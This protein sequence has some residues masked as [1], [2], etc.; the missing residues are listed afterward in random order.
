MGDFAELN[1]RLKL[2]VD[3]PNNTIEIL[4]YMASHC[5]QKPTELPDHPLFN[6]ARWESML[7]SCSDPSGDSVKVAVIEKDSSDG[8]LFIF[9]RSVYKDRGEAEL[10]FNW[11][12]PH[13][14]ALW[15]EFLGYIKYDTNKHPQLIYYTDEGIRFMQI[16]REESENISKREVTF[17]WGISSA[18]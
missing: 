14:D 11:I 2:K 9:V 5:S 3:T 16:T 15:I 18:T 4:R 6:A 1:I 12:F 7:D 17:K 10:F 13:I 8:S